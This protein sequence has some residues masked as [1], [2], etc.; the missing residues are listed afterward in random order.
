VTKLVLPAA[1]FV[2][3]FGDAGAGRQALVLVLSALLVVA[4]GGARNLVRVR[5]ILVSVFAA[6]L[7]LWTLLGRPGE[8]G[9]TAVARLPFALAMALRFTAF[10][11]SGVLYLTIAPPEDFAAALVLLGL[12]D[13]VAFAV[14]LAF[15]WVPVLYDSIEG[16]REAQLSRGIPVDRGSPLRRLRLSVALLAPA[17]HE[18]F[19]RAERTAMV[20]SLRA[21]DSGPRTPP[22][23]RRFG[24]GDVAVTALS[25]AAAVLAVVA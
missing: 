23:P 24:A 8:E 3:P 1:L 13:R 19:R 18:A 25:V 14:L 16:V 10:L 15:R 17:V 20:L 11:V 4:A 6:S 5:A 22:A 2:L 21:F 12:P 9:A 7:L